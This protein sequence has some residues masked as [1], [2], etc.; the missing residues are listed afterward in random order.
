[1]TVVVET[2]LASGLARVLYELARLQMSIAV[3]MVSGRRIEVCVE[4]CDFQCFQTNLMVARCRAIVSAQVLKPDPRVLLKMSYKYQQQ[5]HSQLAGR[6]N[7][8]NRSG[9]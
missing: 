1:M 8:W 6:G 2:L 3:A 4:D 9:R 5:S 7:R